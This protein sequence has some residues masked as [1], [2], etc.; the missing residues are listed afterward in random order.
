MPGRRATVTL[1]AVVE[2]RSDLARG[3]R[4]LSPA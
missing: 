1:E 3:Q 4:H 2:R